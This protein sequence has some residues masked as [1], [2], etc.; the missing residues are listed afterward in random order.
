MKQLDILNAMM[1]AVRLHQARKGE[2]HGYVLAF[3]KDGETPSIATLC[4]TEESMALIDSIMLALN[5]VAIIGSAIIRTLVACDMAP[6]A[7]RM[8]VEATPLPSAE[9]IALDF[10]DF[11]GA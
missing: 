6:D 1:E 4:D 8:I 3:F 10:V 5:E 9:E 11:D 7:A 2:V